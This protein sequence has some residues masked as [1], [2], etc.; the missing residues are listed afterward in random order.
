MG[1]T[2]TDMMQYRITAIDSEIRICEMELRALA[3]KM[4]PEASVGAT[5]N[6]IAAYGNE[7]TYKKNVI[8]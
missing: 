6:W 2:L 4:S 7:F 8:L 5:K 3:G 1:E